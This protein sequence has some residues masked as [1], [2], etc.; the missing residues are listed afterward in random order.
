MPLG[1]RIVLYPESEQ[2][3]KE[4]AGAYAAFARTGSPNGRG[5]PVWPA[6]TPSTRT[7][8]IWDVPKSQAVNNPDSQELA[9]LKGY[10]PKRG[11]E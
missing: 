4:I 9:F 1:A 5:L 11:F 10:P 6:Y 8:M 3:S 7:T 2:L